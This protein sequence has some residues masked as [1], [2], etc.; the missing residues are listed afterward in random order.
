ML[1]H[2]YYFKLMGDMGYGNSVVSDNC[3]G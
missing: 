1:V 3:L 2:P